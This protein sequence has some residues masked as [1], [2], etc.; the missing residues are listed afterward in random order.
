MQFHA[1]GVLRSSS[2]AWTAAGIN[3]LSN[4]GGDTASTRVPITAN[5]S[6]DELQPGV[7]NANRKTIMPSNE[8]RKQLTEPIKLFVCPNGVRYLQLNFPNRW[9]N[10]ED[11]P[12]PQPSTAI[13]VAP[14]A[15]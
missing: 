15:R 3:R 13:I 7:P 11:N 8:P 4:S 9:P 6:H 2:T 10:K 1:T 12:S 5:S 14:S